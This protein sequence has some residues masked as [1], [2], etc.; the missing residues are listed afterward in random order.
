V[1]VF[2][3][4]A[5]AW[6]LALLAEASGRDELLHHDALLTGGLPFALA[7]VLFLLAWQAMVAAMMLPSSVPLVVLFAR[8]AARQPRPRAALAAFLGGY[9]LVWTGFGWAALAG[10]AVL[11][12]AVE[13][14]PWLAARPWL[15]AGGALVAAGAFQFSGLK[16]RCLT[17]CRNPGA[18]LLAR[19]RRGVWGAFRLGRDHGLSCL[20]CCWALMLVLFAVGV[21]NLAWMALLTA[22]TLVEKTAP[23]GERLVPVTGVAFLAWGA[24]VALH[25]AWLPAW[26]ALR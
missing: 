11:H 19:Y 7:L 26:L 21:A 16:D 24:F 22:L 23:R 10:D 1:A 9:A 13:R 17:L 25:P 3:A 15:L 14:T 4:I 18:F 20:G 2:A 12:A 6:A 8:A 5:L